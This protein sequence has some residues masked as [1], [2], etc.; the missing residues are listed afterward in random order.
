VPWA[1]G[2]P[3]GAARQVRELRMDWRQ[4]AGPCLARALAQTLWAGEGFYLQA[5]RA[6]GPP[7]GAAV[8][9]GA[10]LPASVRRRVRRRAVAR[11]PLRAQAA[12]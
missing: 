11:A 12:S 6:R 3:A 9:N 2:H 1:D 4:A 10:P 5:R 8:L 7:P